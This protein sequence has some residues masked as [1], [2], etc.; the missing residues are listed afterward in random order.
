[1]FPRFAERGEQGGFQQQDANEC[2]VELM[3]VLKRHLNMKNEHEKS[4]VDTFFGLEFDTETKCVESEEEPV[5]KSKE[6]FLQYNCYIDKDV[7][8]L[9][10]GLKN[11]LQESMTKRSEILDRDAEYMK[12]L[13]VSRLPGYLTV[14][15]VRFQFKQKDA[16]NAKILKDVKFPM[17]LD[18]FDLCSPELQEK[19]I[20]MRNKFKEYEDAIGLFSH[21][22]IETLECVHCTFETKI[23]T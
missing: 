4:V 5:T 18:T 16:I 12:T 6:H 7:K 21:Q 2:W 8:Y 23:C 14:Q 9:F 10:S 15:M 22:R 11:R 1:M 20:P 13:K 19:L 3:G 17:M